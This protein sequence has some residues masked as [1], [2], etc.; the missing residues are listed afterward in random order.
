MPVT[1]PPLPNPHQQRRAVEEVVYNMFAHHSEHSLY[2]MLQ[3]IEKYSV[4]LSDGDQKKAIALKI[5][6]EAG[7]GKDLPP[8]S[9]ADIQ[10]IFRLVAAEVA[11]SLEAE[12][13]L[14]WGKVLYDL[15]TAQKMLNPEEQKFFKGMMGKVLR[16]EAVSREEAE[17]LLR[18][19]TRKG[20]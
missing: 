3:Y 13:T 19:Y 5:L 2:Q 8:E 4:I 15:S 17:A 18:L 16:K 6:I 1:R 11:K 10:R 20:F 9:L 7:R 12:Q 14:S